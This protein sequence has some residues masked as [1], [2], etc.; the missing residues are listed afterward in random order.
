MGRNT[1]GTQPEHTGKRELSGCVYETDGYFCGQPVRARGYCM[2]HY[3]ILGRKGAFKDIRP[4]P[5]GS[6]ADTADRNM[7]HLERARLQLERHTETFVQHLLTA[8]ENAAKKGDSRPAEW[9]LLHS[10]AV[11]PVLTGGGASSKGGAEVPGIR[12]LVGVQLTGTAASQPASIPQTIAPIT[13]ENAGA[14]F[15]TCEALPVLDAELS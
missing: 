12:V 15:Q 1:A 10:R 8:A 9:G 5:P 3:K 6:D 14:N 4:I 11:E 7:G 13:L 2:R